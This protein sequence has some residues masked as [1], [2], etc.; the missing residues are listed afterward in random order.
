MS[1]GSR[2]ARLWGC[3]HGSGP[4]SSAST[5][6]KRWMGSICSATYVWGL[7]L[8][9]P[10]RERQ[11]RPI[12]RSRRGSCASHVSRW[13]QTSLNRQVM[14]RCSSR[15]VC[16]NLGPAVCENERSSAKAFYCCCSGRPRD[17]LSQLQTHAERTKC[18]LYLY[19]VQ[20]RTSRVFSSKAGV[21]QCPIDTAPLIFDP[22]VRV[23]YSYLITCQYLVRDRLA[24]PT[25]IRN[26]NRSCVRAC[27]PACLA[28]QIRYVPN[29]P[30][31]ASDL[32]RPDY[33]RLYCVTPGL[34]KL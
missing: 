17:Y 4:L 5:Q 3:W 9:A 21:S 11:Q 13:Q 23:Q 1:P 29:S 14:R 26:R 12:G 28:L 25:I 33:P 16:D 18:C 22:K 19:L 30:R 20:R 31:R 34:F 7:A 24:C 2:A 8:V 10:V 6:C 27:V 15:A 32:G